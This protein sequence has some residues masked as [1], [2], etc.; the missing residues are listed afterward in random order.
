[1]KKLTALLVTGITVTSLV[2]GTVGVILLTSP[3]DNVELIPMPEKLVLNSTKKQKT[4]VGTSIQ[5]RA[6]VQPAEA[7]HHLIWSSSNPEVLKVERG[8][9]HTIGVVTCLA[10][11]DEQVTI[12]VESALN[13]N[14]YKEC[15]VDYQQRF[16]TT[17]GYIGA[18]SFD[19][20]E[21]VSEENIIDIHSGYQHGGNWS[22]TNSKIYYDLNSFAEVSKGTI[23][24]ENYYQ[25]KIN[26]LAINPQIQNA[27]NSVYNSYGA[28]SQS[29][30]YSD[31]K[32]TSI[33]DYTH[34]E[35]TGFSTIVASLEYGRT[36]KFGYSLDD[37]SNNAPVQVSFYNFWKK[38]LEEKE[39][40]YMFSINVSYGN[41]TKDIKC[42]IGLTE[43]TAAPTSILLNNTTYV[44]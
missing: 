12:R 44:I 18:Y 34:D 3:K 41:I 23:E 25:F 7:S 24:I 32:T 11:F 35:G 6:T 28:T 21:D 19:T 27:W 42:N 16:T 30:F 31:F 38:L 5:L 14:I 15:V 40:D 1:M 10:E 17:S 36:I 26:S 43:Y 39:F 13:H 9:D 37:V 22:L 8:E 33:F 20:F 4:A 29:L 2:A